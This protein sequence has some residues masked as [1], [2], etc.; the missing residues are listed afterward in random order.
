MPTTTTQDFTGSVATIGARTNA[1]AGAVTDFTAEEARMF[2]SQMQAGV[3]K[4]TDGF[5]VVAGGAA[6]MNV[7]V[8][9]GSAK[10]DIAVVAG[11]GSGQEKYMARF[12]DVTKVFALDAADPS[13]PRIDEIYLIVS[14]AAYDGGSVSLPRI[15]VRKGD[16]SGSPAAPG[17]DSSWDAYLLLSSI[18]IPASAADILA[19]TFTDSRVFAYDSGNYGGWAPV[20]SVLAFAGAIAPP[21]WFL[22]NGQAISRTTWANLFNLVGTL[23]G[24]GDGSTTFNIPDLR[25]RFVLG[26][27]ASGTGSTLG[28][29]GGTIDHTHTGPS[30]TH[31]GPS[32]THTGPS[33]N[34]SI[35]DSGEA[36]VG[37]SGASIGLY[38]A[39]GNKHFH[40]HT[41]PNTNNGGTGN[42]GAAGTGNT[43][44]AGT[45]ATGT[46]NPP[47]M[48]LNYIIK[49]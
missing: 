26:K 29:T 37:A 2:I 9:S 32:H 41:I 34:H 5:Q 25:Q 20:G 6:T 45:G 14:D 19:A 11:T 17:P 47:F 43:G 27:A 42:T 13:N 3:L 18:T 10:S 33:H 12:D 40:T 8:G 44:S 39:T 24:I 28:G 1:A 46:G 49:A 38:T 36:I 35:N 31:T 48:A 23:Y 30:H 4:P 21:G 15:G 22:C 7:V 16:P